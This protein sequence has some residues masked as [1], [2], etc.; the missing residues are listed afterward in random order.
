MMEE[1][2]TAF[3]KNHILPQILTRSYGSETEPLAVHEQNKTYCICKS[4][5]GEGEMVA[6]DKCN[7][8]YHP[9]C[10][11]LKKLPNQKVWYCPSCR[12]K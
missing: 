9:G 5:T 4:K 11:K 2:A 6:C 10:L 8:W 7:N 1:Q 12:K 3:W